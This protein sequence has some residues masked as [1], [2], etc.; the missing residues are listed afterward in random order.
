MVN[1]VR[2]LL[3]AIKYWYIPLIIGILS[4]LGGFYVFTVPLEAYLALSIMFSISFIVFGVFDIFFSLENKN[5]LSW[6]GWYFVNGLLSVIMGWI[7]LF[8]PWLSMST[9]SFFVGFAL[10]F[11]SAQLSGFSFDLK[12]YNESNWIYLLI[13]SIIW[14]ITS[15]VLIAHPIFTGISVA[16]MTGIAMIFTGVSSII[17]SFDLKNIKNFPNRISSQLKDKI[18]LIQNELEAEL[19]KN[20]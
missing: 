2:S 12:Q 17:F 4:I 6:W 18:N 9:F 16:L 11:R 20:K 8:Y 1:L 10:L 13:L 3:Q 7:L 15:F 19:Q 5:T 14:I